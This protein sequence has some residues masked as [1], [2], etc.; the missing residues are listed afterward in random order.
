MATG[1]Y[2]NGASFQG[3]AH[4][5]ILR[6]VRSR[7]AKKGAPKKAVTTPMGNSA[8]DRMVR[9]NA[10]ASAV[11]GADKN[12]T[13]GSIQFGLIKYTPVKARINNGTYR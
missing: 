7:M 4:M 10:S 13:A 12:P 6:V 1:C 9:A 11:R 8:G 5:T 3:V 2:R